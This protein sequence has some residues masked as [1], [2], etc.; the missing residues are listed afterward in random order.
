MIITFLAFLSIIFMNS[1]YAEQSTTEVF[2]RIYEKGI[3]GKDQNGNGTSGSGLTVESAME[4]I[5]FLNKFIRTNNIK[6]IVDI[7]C[8]DWGVMKYIDLTEVDYLGLDVVPF[9]IQNNKTKYSSSHV[10]F[11]LADC[12]HDL[13]PKAD[14]L[15]CKDVL[16]HIPNKE[17]FKIIKQFENYRHILVTSDVE[18][19]S[20]TSHNKDINMGGWRSIDLSAPPFSLA[21]KK[22]LIYPAEYTYYHLKQ[23]FYIKPS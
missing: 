13:L 10:N 23:V 3:W 9:V 15:L 20:L 17:V 22:I 19:T 14:L 18:A 2:S 1:L 8:G 12:I 4:Y 7:G 21:G 6:T 5:V 16:N 11:A